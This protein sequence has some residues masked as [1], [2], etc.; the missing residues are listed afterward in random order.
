MHQTNNY[1][2]S[3][4]PLD[5]AP[6]YDPPPYESATA[7][8]GSHGLDKGAGAGAGG[9]K[10]NPKNWGLKTKIGVGLAVAVAI[11]V[12][13]VGA[14]YGTRNEE[15]PD[16]SRLNYTLTKEYSGTNFFDDFEFYTA[17]DPTHGFVDYVDNRTATLMNLTYASS[18]SAILRV[19]HTESGQQ[20][21]TSGRKSVRITSNTR[22]DLGLFVFDIQ[23]SP[24]GCA[25]WPAVWLSD[26]NN[27][28]SNGEIDILEG[29]NQVSNNRSQTTL[30][31]SS[32][33]KMSHV[34]RK[35]SGSVLATNCWNETDANAG[36]G[37]QGGKNSFGAGFNAHGGGVYAMELR[38]AGIRV[39]FFGRGDE[40]ADLANSTYTNGSSVRPDPSRWGEAMA[41]FPSTDCD[42][43]THFR[44]QSIIANIGVC[45][46]WAGSPAVYTT[47][48]SCPATCATYAETNASAFDKAYWEFNSFRVY[49]AT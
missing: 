6:N 15:Y 18:T 21:R 10:W 9:S 46:D 22:Y 5:H 43:S 28:P 37:V 3:S 49:T 23:H 14:Y 34:K 41:D 25:T 2:Q 40:P 38:D 39:W 48:D 24:Y 13:V 26:P 32:D 44:N 35:E 36:C 8:A 4:V 33:C 17:T 27:W 7:A 30:H 45:G 31:T 19:D 1:T 12:I 29:V 42:V 20:I 16:Y 11:V 47:K